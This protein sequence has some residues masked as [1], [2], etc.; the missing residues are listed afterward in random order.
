MKHKII[1]GDAIEEMKKLSENSIDACVTDPPYNL[2]SVTK[3]FQHSNR[4]NE[5][6]ATNA[7]HGYGRMLR[8]SMGGF[9]GKEWDG[10]GISFDVKLWEEV[11]RVLKPGA[12]ILVF[13]GTRTYHRMVCAVEDAG[14]ECRDM[15]NWVYGSG[16]PKS[17][18]IAKSL[19][20]ING[21]E[22]EEFENPLK[23]K[24]TSSHGKTIALNAKNGVGI[25]SPIPVSEEAIQWSGWGS[26]L[27]P[28]HEPILLARKPISERNIASNVLRWGVG[29]IN[30][31]GCRIPFQGKK[32]IGDVNRFTG[33]K[34]YS[35]E[36]GWNNNNLIVNEYDASKGRFP[37]NMILS[38]SCKDDE[39]VEGKVGKP[40]IRH[41]LSGIERINIESANFK[42]INSMD[43]NDKGTIHT[44]P[45]CVCRMLDEQSGDLNR[46]KQRNYTYENKGGWKQT[47][48]V[49]NLIDYGDKGGCSRFFYQAKA[50]Q[51]ERW[52]YCTIC[53]QAYPMKERDKHIYE[54]YELKE[55]TP[56]N[57]KEEIEKHLNTSKAN[58]IL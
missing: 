11:Y 35:V 12:H 18:D 14:F 36:K 39:L 44:N 51:A 25:I 21:K 19:D 28:S 20:K 53:K 6:Y 34:P 2:T 54:R 40:K 26:N 7:E 22:R 56:Q 38:C 9:M 23:A 32:D 42:R 31:D 13:G 29:G 37:S 46:T 3:R 8:A 10:T 41:H 55:S 57:I 43:Y 52:F 58:S 30:V 45:N 47:S 50:S 17:L 33:L 24:Q 48:K 27:K 1:C 16:F 5:K 49:K 15:I 4:E